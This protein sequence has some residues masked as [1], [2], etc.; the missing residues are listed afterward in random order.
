M[1]TSAIICDWNGTLIDQR[2]ESPVFRQIAVDLFWRSIPC[3]I[4]RVA[5]LLKTRKEL[6]V[7]YRQKRQEA[8]F[9]YVVELYK[10]FNDRVIK[11]LPVSFIHRSV[12]K[13]AGKPQT[14]QKLDF[15]VLRPVT[16]HHRA[17]I[18]TGILSAGYVYGIQAILKSAGYSDSFDFLEANGLK[19]SG[20]RAIGLELNIYKNKGQVLL[21]LLRD[22]NI[23]AKRVVYIGDSPDDAGCFE[24]AGYPIVA[25]LASEALKEEFARKYHAFIP[26]SEAD[27]ARYL[28][29]T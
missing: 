22:R 28:Q 13:Y 25:F 15:R 24:L 27:L 20:G 4:N 12:E 14:L 17:G 2:D 16:A 19:E 29:S 9:D 6:E 26:A 10:I 21:R 23:D 5:R 7:L 11:S 3:H 8:E 1:T 18:T